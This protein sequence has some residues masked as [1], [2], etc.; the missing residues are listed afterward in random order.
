MNK[1]IKII[2]HCGKVV[3]WIWEVLMFTTRDIG[4]FTRLLF[5]H[6]VKDDEF[7]WPLIGIPWVLE[8]SANF[9]KYSNVAY[10]TW[11]VQQSITQVIFLIQ[12]S[13]WWVL[14]TSNRFALDFRVFGIIFSP[15]SAESHYEFFNQTSLF[16]C[17]LILL[18]SNINMTW[19]M[20][21]SAYMCQL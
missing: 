2:D 1:I 9:Q 8:F 13:I 12:L 11:E 3:K 18:T 4:T 17:R 7:Y 15:N 20:E 6:A 16:S 21:L 5:S 19:V 14:L 10:V